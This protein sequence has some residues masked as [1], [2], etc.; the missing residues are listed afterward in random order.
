MRATR[1]RA[2]V[3]AAL[4]V[5][6]AAAIV[7]AVGDDRLRLDAANALLLL[8]AASGL[9]LAMGPAGLPS[10][11][12]GAFVGVGAYATA[13]L[14]AQHGW[15][16]VAATVAGVGVAVVGGIVLARAVVRL[17][18][19][20]VALGTWLAAWTFA[21]AVSAF[22]ATTGGQRGLALGPTTIHLRAVGTSLDI[23]PVGFFVLAS[24]AAAIVLAVVDAWQ[25]RWGPGLVAGRED[26][27]AAAAAGVP[28]LGQRRAAFVAS[29]AAGGLAGALLVQVAGVADPTAYGPILSVKLFLVVLLG[30]ADSVLGP[31]AG[32]VA[33][34]AVTRLAAGMADVADVDR[35]RVEPFAAAVVLLVV[36]LAG[37]DGIVPLLRRALRRRDRG[38]RRA[39]A[40]PIPVCAP[41]VHMRPAVRK[42]GAGL[43]LEGVSVAFGGLRAL[44]GVTIDVAPGTCHAVV[45]PNGSGKTTSLR[46]AAGVVAP[47]AGR[48]LLGGDDVTGVTSE[49][50]RIAGIARTLQRTG[51]APSLSALANVVSGMEPRRRAALLP[52][53]AATPSTRRETVVVRDE[54][55]RL[56]ALVGLE[57]KGDIDV[58][59]LDATEQR[60]VQLARAL[61][62]SPR[63]LL[64]DEPS[65]GMTAADA[66]R[67]RS[68]LVRLRDDGLTVVVVEH[69]L[70]LV[71]ALADRVTVLD[72]G[73]VVAEGAVDEVARDEA[74]RAA[75]LGAA[76]L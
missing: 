51:V 61:A 53:L 65:A 71:R 33:L 9:Q 67:L 4:A 45:G 14:R 25:R 13:V 15:D 52:A 59:A 34:A 1:R 36:L 22:P 7:M 55:Q 12:Q 58:R 18:P 39:V 17:T 26:A 8:A 37:G 30:G 32:L 54:A 57:R 60:L 64:L 5:L 6:A 72:A 74:V 46:V 63:V 62:S 42:P 48:V 43:R 27:V 76:T 69:N 24:V 23:G 28:V 73:E 3:V 47:S 75:Y 16:P 56:L 49:Q 38:R 50:R 40:A 31:A 2:L 70:R 44:A 35:F 21:L 41:R 19:A 20:F 29:A 66:D 10:L 11:A 68:V